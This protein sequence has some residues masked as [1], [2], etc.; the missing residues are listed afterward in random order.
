MD[1]SKSSFS[2]LNLVRG[3]YLLNVG[4]SN[5]FLIVPGTAERG[6]DLSPLLKSERKNY[7]CPHCR[8]KSIRIQLLH[9]KLHSKTLCITSNL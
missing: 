2:L 3:P 6:E 8:L 9:H 4:Q 1:S 5:L 7:K